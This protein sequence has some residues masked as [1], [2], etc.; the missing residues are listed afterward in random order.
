MPVN[1]KWDLI[2]RLRVNKGVLD[3]ILS[4]HLITVCRE[5]DLSETYNGHDP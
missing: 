5:I 4:L 2:R 3:Y 1:G